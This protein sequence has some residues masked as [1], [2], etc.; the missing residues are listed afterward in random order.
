M[1]LLSN[2]TTMPLL[3]KNK[4]YKPEHEQANI[5]DTQLSLNAA[6]LL[7]LKRAPSQKMIPKL[8]RKQTHTEPSQKK[9]IKKA[10][11]SSKKK[12]RFLP[13]HAVAI[14]KEWILS[15]EH[16]NFPYPTEDEKKS[17]MDK[18]GINSKQLKYWFINA[19][20]RLWK[21]TLLEKEK[22]SKSIK[23]QKKDNN[24]SS[25]SNESEGEDNV[26]KSALKT[27]F[28]KLPSLNKVPVIPAMNPSLLHQQILMQRLKASQMPLSIST[29][30]NI[31]HSNLIRHAEHIAMFKGNLSFF[32][33]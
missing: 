4:T 17:L 7:L 1:K 22:Q 32:L 12:N 27:V 14:L 31:V 18:T 21:Q 8:A 10:N 23:K 11:N 30:R 19:R 28:T 33:S 26:S 20:R 16:F 2:N 13:N 3:V 25:A 24:P 29:S 9:A 15:P 6:Q 5:E